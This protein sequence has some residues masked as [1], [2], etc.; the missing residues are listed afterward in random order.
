MY[1][2]NS[3]FR[4]FVNDFAIKHR[5]TVEASLKCMQ[6]KDEFKRLNKCV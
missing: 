4:E 2:K 1:T 3:E 5:T 6:V